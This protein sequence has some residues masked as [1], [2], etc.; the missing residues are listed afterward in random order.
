[1]ALDGTGDARVLEGTAPSDPGMEDLALAERARLAYVAESTH[2]LVFRHPLIRSTVVELATSEERRR[3][4]H[5][6]AQIWTEQGDRR[7]WHLGHATVEPDEEVATLL[8]QAAHHILRRGDGVGAVSALTRA[9]DLSPLGTDRGRRLAEAAYIGAD[10]TGQ[11]RSASQL[12]ADAHR[13]DPEFTASLQAAATAAFVS[14]Q[15]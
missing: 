2:R 6:L 14:D 12:L 15:R 5:E 11:L 13:A 10:V 9:A 4:H 7:A 1:M 3:A 8:E